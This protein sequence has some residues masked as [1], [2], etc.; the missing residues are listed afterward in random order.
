[1]SAL[2]LIL[3]VR[4]AGGSYGE[5][6]AVA[7]SFAIAVAVGAPYSGR[8]VDRRGP[9]HALRLRLVL[10]PLLLG[11]VGLLGE[12]GAP[13]VAIAVTAA[14]AGLLLPPVSSALRSIWP[15]VVGEDD[16]STAYSIDAALQEVI[17]IGG[18]MLV[19]ALSTIDPSAG[20]FG[21]AVTSAVGT[22][23]FVRLPPVRA[24]RPVDHPR[25]SR[26][27]ALSSVGVRTI[28]LLSLFL[29]LGFGAV[30]IAV[31]AFAEGE[32]S[33]ALAG[34]VLAGFSA[35]SL[36]GGLLAGLRPSRDE[37]RRVLVGTAVL[38]A[39]LALPL[40]AGSVAGMTALLFIAGLP[41]APVVAALYGLIGKVAAPGTVAEAFSW[42]GTAVSLGVAG[43]S[44]TGGWLIDDHGWQASIAL[45]AMLVAVGAGLTIL[46]RG[47]L[48]PDPGS[49]VGVA[50]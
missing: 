41:I 13:I 1:M 17:F 9:T 10:F 21:A 11:L 39:L 8:L 34:I 33:R 25:G 31:P 26:L 6:G 5:A 7:A 27:G 40:A 12:A 28:A 19:A 2:A 37:R 14:L 42:F 48:V 46:R 44:V 15:D 49:P 4:G 22:L 23:A 18:P 38:A 35:G 16:V 29:G 45:G 47:T 36:L 32:G 43:G 50:L 30:E 3:L 24:A 20:V